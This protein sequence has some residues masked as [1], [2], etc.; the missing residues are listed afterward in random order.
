[1]CPG[2]G[3]GVRVSGWL[4]LRFIIIIFLAGKTRVRVRVLPQLLHFGAA[5]VRVK[6][7]N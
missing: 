6:W 3:L 4:M 7:P 5:L 1:M 2:D